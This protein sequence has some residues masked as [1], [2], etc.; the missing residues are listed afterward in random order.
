MAHSSIHCY[1]N[2]LMCGQGGG[3][4]QYSMMGWGAEG[5]AAVM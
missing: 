4:M 3:H 2:I 5:L 1:G